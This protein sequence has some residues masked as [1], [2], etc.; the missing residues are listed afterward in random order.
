MNLLI[1]QILGIVVTILVIISMQVKNIRYA[2]AINLICNILGA[3]SYIFTGGISGTGIYAIAVFQCIV[4]FQY[5]KKNIKAPNFLKWIFVAAYLI[6]SVTTYKNYYDILSALAALTCAFALSQEESS[7]YRVFMVFNG[8]L[9][10]TYDVFVGAYTM[11][12]SHGIALIAAVVG[13]I[14][15]DLKRITNKQ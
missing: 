11:I 1:S 7:K 8:I 6:C 10:M 9:W 4:Y 14:R 2:L 15:L 5:S 12:I 3:L 13:I